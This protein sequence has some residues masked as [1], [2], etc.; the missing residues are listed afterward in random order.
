M[1]VPVQQPLDFAPV[2]LRAHG[3]RDAHMPLRGLRPGAPDRGREA[4]DLP[5]HA[6]DERR[7]RR[8]GHWRQGHRGWGGRRCQHPQKSNITSIM[9]R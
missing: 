4:L 7:F 8:Y 2:E 5:A 6:H 9:L 3:L 1:S